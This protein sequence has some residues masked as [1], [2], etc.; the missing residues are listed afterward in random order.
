M[1]STMKLLEKRCNKHWKQ[2]YQQLSTGRLKTELRKM[3][4]SKPFFSLWSSK[5]HAWSFHVT[6]L[7]DFIVAGDCKAFPIPHWHY[8]WQM[9][10]KYGSSHLQIFYKTWQYCSVLTI[11]YPSVSYQCWR[12][13][14]V[15]S[16]EVTPLFY[17]FFCS[18]HDYCLRTGIT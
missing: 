5:W 4:V 1:K 8:W 7:L 11:T 17:S 13:L 3:S 12:Q 6:L 9:V 18:V 16:K 2:C 14:M 10:T 15:H